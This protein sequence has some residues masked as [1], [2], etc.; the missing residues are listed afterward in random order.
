MSKEKNVY[1][2]LA[3]MLCEEF[4]RKQSASLLANLNKRNIDTLDV[5]KNKILE[6]VSEEL[7]GYQDDNNRSLSEEEKIIVL[8]LVKKELW[9]YG[10]ID[11]LIHDKGIS[12]CSLHMK[13][14][15]YDD[16]MS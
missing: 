1:Q 15:C 12:D 13:A 16:F 3:R 14:W 6:D 4:Q 11:D 7:L 5:S 9:G 10:A 2:E 8:D